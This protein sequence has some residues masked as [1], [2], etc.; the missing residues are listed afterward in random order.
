MLRGEKVVLR[1]RIEADVAVLHAEMYD[2]VLMRSRSDSRPWRPISPD[3]P[4]APYRIT[5]PDDQFAVFSV[6]ELATGELAGEALLWGIDTHSRSA[7]IGL[8]LRAACRGRGLG[9][10]IVRVLCEYSFAVRGL[11]RIGIET[12]SDNRAMLGAAERA[13]FVREGVLRKAAW[14]NGEFVDEVVLGLLVDEWAHLKADRLA[15]RA[16]D[17]AIDEAGM[18]S[19]PASDPPAF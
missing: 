16:A 7:H 11:H 8:G 12:L 10:D 9:I 2:D 19:F 17:D 4:A 13:G 1:A 3:A 14:V 15:R 6:V 18:E 5:D